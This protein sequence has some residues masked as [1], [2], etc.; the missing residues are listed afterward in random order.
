MKK[1]DPI[2]K[3]LNRLGELRHEV[4]TERTAQEIR[5]F[6]THGSNLV[7]A[8]AAKIVGEARDSQFVPDLV[9]AFHR[10]MTNPQQ[11]DK[12]CAAITEIVGSLYE[13]DYSEPDVYRPGLRHVQLEASFG[14]PVD[15]A[16]ALRGISAQGLLRTRY[17][18]ALTE[19]LPLLIDP[20]PPARIGAVR[21]F[22]VNG[23]SAGALILR[24]K[25]MT[26]DS[27][28]EVLAE[29]FSGLLSAAPERSLKF[30]AGYMDAEDESIS[31]AAIWA[32]GQ[33]HSIAA[34]ACLREKWD[35]TAARSFRKTILAAIAASRCDDATTFLC[36]IIV[37][38][39]STTA[40]DAMATLS[41]YKSS[42]SL[43]HA[44]ADAVLTRGDR[45]LQRMFEQEFAI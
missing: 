39:D 13:L 22:A 40:A 9:S 5:H 41:G 38:E 1:S 43:R 19:V 29:C 45:Q 16:A 4:P 44:V 2:E 30:V 42:Q 15:T 28:P 32:L 6:L 12:R 21:A 11:I 37:D 34:F 33:S 10:F 36:S 35:R 27:E 31:A 24:L 25:V 26:G 8:K 14:P 3:A 20:E 23:G 7:V 18:E 17:A